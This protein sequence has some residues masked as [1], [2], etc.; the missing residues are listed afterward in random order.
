MFKM[1]EIAVKRGL[2]V[3]KCDGMALAVCILNDNLK[4]ATG[5]VALT[6]NIDLKG[7]TCSI[8]R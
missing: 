1:L 7:G 4:N 5:C 2:G 6:H 8:Y 3:I